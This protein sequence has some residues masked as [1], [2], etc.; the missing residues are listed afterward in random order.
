VAFFI[1]SVT[2]LEKLRSFRIQLDKAGKLRRV[3][4]GLRVQLIGTASFELAVL[5][6]AGPIP[7]FDLDRGSPRSYEHC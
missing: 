5:G 6:H 4:R 1:C 2:T 7:V 3:V